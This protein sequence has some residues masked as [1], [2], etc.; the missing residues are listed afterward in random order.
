MI[1]IML[2]CH[3]GLQWHFP[4]W[5]WIVAAIDAVVVFTLRTYG[6]KLALRGD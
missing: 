3:Y 2:L 5:L 1:D 4:D 6:A